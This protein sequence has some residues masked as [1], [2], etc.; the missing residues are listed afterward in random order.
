MGVVEVVPAGITVL[1]AAVVAVVAVTEVEG[2]VEVVGTVVV[3]STV[4][5][6]VEEA[7]DGGKSHHRFREF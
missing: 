5:D 6:T 1:S 2:V 7:E 3:L 4:E